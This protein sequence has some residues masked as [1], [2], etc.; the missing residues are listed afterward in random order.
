[1]TVCIYKNNKIVTDSRCTY[2]GDYV[3]SDKFKKVGN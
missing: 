3:I 2:Q 1:M